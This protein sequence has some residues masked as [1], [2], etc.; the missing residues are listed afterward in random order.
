MNTKKIPSI[1]ELSKWENLEGK[2][3]LNDERKVLLSKARIQLKSAI[4]DS[5][6]LDVL[7][8]FNAH[9]KEFYERFKPT[10]DYLV[11]WYK[12]K[13]RCF[14]E[15][16]KLYP[17]GFYCFT[18]RKQPKTVSK[19]RESTRKKLKKYGVYIKPEESYFNNLNSKNLGKFPEDL[20][21]DEYVKVYENAEKVFAMMPYEFEQAYFGREEIKA[22]QKL[23]EK[24]RQSFRYK[25]KRRND[26]VSIE[27]LS[28]E[29]SP[30]IF[31]HKLI[32]DALLDPN[33]L[34]SKRDVLLKAKLQKAIESLPEKQKEA[35][36]LVYLKGHS[37]AEA[38]RLLGI[39]EP[40]LKERLDYAT[41]TLRNKHPY[42]FSQ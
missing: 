33:T 5:R 24:V 38:S 36:T 11:A 3:L 1:N 4:K 13:E 20:F 34:E 30:F 35:V 29:D 26:F 23:P 40:S 14:E 37:Q 17:N 12:K 32:Q 10:A 22:Y 42:L 21:M 6:L 9:Y 25:V 2:G 31:P 8:K 7:S 27:Q 15:Y 19:L 28:I 39:K 41:N 18:N 16:Q